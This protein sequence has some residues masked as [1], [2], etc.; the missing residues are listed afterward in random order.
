M[1]VRLLIVLKSGET[2]RF[3]KDCED[4]AAAAASL[5]AIQ[6]S[7]AAALGEERW[8]TADPTLFNDSENVD[9]VM[10]ERALVRLGMFA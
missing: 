1:R 5:A 8:T 4:E 9:L 6:A 7:Y 10:A 2:Q 3:F